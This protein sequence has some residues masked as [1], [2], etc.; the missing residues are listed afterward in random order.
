MVSCKFQRYKYLECLL[1]Y[2][3][4]TTNRIKV[5]CTTFFDYHSGG[6]TEVQL[7]LPNQIKTTILVKKIGIVHI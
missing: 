3:F 2:P 4:S 6:G 7:R 1:L 5:G